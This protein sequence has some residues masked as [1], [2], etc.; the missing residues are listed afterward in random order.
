MPAL[1]LLYP[2]AERHGHR[3]NWSH[4]KFTRRQVRKIREEFS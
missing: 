4:R 3:S 2:V 1:K